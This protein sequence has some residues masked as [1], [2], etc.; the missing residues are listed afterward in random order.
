[1][2]DTDEVKSRIEFESNE[3]TET[4]ETEVEVEESTETKVE[5]ETETPEVEESEDPVFTFGDEAAPASQEQDNSVIRELRAQNRE[6]ARKLKE[7]AQTEAKAETPKLPEKPTLES[8]DYDEEAFER[9]LTSYYEAKRQVEAAE[10]AKEDELKQQQ[11]A[12]QQRLQAY[13][14]RAAELKVKDFKD[15]EEEVASVLSV[16]QQAILFGADDTAALVYTL[17]KHPEKLKELASIKDPAKFAFAAA[18][19]ETQMK[20]TTRKPKVSPEGQVAPGSGSLQGGADQTLERLRA[21]AAKTGDYTKV[22]AYRR[23]LNQAK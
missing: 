17:G 7:T 1:M 22:G 12:Q 14:S 16:A 20:V 9:N 10:K 11:E 4:E 23:Q 19:L 8:C 15:V 13:Q 21:E 2:A 5:T 6:L 3:A 18:K